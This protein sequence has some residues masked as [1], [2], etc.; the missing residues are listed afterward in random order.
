MKK[1]DFYSKLIEVIDQTNQSNK[2]GFTMISEKLEAMNTTISKIG[3]IS[4]R[5]VD[6]LDNVFDTLHDI[7]TVGKER[8][9]A[10]KQIIESVKDGG[11]AHDVCLGVRHGIFGQNANEYSSIE[12]LL[13]AIETLAGTTPTPQWTKPNKNKSSTATVS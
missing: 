8:T 12:S 13:Y 5:G 11:L 2:A 7:Y 1:N 3:A 9:E 4:A 6:H 10:L